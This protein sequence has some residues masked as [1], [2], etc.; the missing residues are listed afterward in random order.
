[1]T[2]D[3]NIIARSMIPASK[4]GFEAPA[5][6]YHHGHGLG[7]INPCFQF[8]ALAMARFTS[9]PGP[10]VTAG[11]TIRFTGGKAEQGPGLWRP[12]AY[13]DPA[14][15]R[16]Y[17]FMTN[18]RKLSA[19]T[20]AHIYKKRRPM[21]IFFNCLK[22]N[23]K[24]KSFAG[25]SRNAVLTQVWVAMCAYLIPAFMKFPARMGPSIS[26]ILHLMTLNF[27]SEWT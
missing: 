20:M 12:F 27:S 10:S 16:D 8:P 14:H 4:H 13:H 1:L 24:I 26:R 11:L 3:G 7:K 22:Q 23:L 15:D 5:P 6:K 25:P 18:N 21:E 9:R 17:V 19:R 2:H